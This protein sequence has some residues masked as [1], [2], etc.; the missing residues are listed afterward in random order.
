M[1]ILANKLEKK[2]LDGLLPALKLLSEDDSLVKKAL[3]NQFTTLI[4]IV[5]ENFSDEGYQKMVHTIFPI[6]GELLYDK[7]E[8][9][10]DR[11]VQVVAEM[12]TVVKEKENEWIMKL[13]LDMAHDEDEKLRESAVKLLN[14]MAPDMGQEL[15]E[16]FIVQELK[17][18]GI[19]NQLNVRCAVAKNLLNVSRQI[20]M[21]FFTS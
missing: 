10:R 21:D 7:D 5:L 13:T 18:L 16:Y 15:C 11:A 14:E 1:P 4:R 6:M 2:Q 3:L 9:I 8:G 19:D 12:R 20:K 17:S